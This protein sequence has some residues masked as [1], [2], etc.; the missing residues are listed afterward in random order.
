[1]VQGRHEPVDAAPLQSVGEPVPGGERSLVHEAHVDG[2]DHD[3]ACH[4]A[5]MLDRVGD[6]R[7]GA[8]RVAPEDD[9]PAL[10]MGFHNGVE[11]RDELRVGVPAAGWRGI[12]APVPAS[13]VGDLAVAGAS[14]RFRAV[15]HIAAGRG[16]PVEKRDRRA[17][18]DRLSRQ[19]QTR[20]LDR[21]LRGLER[22]HLA[23]QVGAPA[24]AL[25]SAVPRASTSR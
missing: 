19:G 14:Q 25:S 20:P 2:A 5:G 24:R 7:M 10:R 8:H 21:E 11:V 12:G 15:D 17:L 16:D 6:G 13:V 4:P 22:R 3:E 23:G 18:S 1:V 9:G